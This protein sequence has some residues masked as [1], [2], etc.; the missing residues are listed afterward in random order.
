MTCSG[1]ATTTMEFICSAVISE[2]GTDDINAFGYTF[3]AN[4]NAT[5]STAGTQIMTLRPKTT[6]NGITNRMRV[7]YIDV[8]IFNLG[9]SNQHVRWDLCIGQTITGGTWS[10]VNTTYSGIEVNTGGTLVGSPEI[11]IDAG[12]VPV[13]GNDK[14]FVN[15][16]VIS[17][18][19]M[20]LD[21][22]GNNRLL[23]SLT[24]KVTSLAGTPVVYGGIKFREIR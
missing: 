24:L 7:A 9:A 16:A 6:F 5:V 19:P 22:A 17:R 1:L 4:A 2:G 3:E 18:Y 20:T 21:A 10:D 23:G 15:V 8:E 12:W 13:G 11:V 14:G